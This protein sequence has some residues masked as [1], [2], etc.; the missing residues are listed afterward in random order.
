MLD[1]DTAK[2]TVTVIRTLQERGVLEKVIDFFQG[3]NPYNIIVVGSS[4]TGKTSFLKHMVG[5]EP[6]IDRFDRSEDTEAKTGN[7]GS[8]LFRLETV[9]GQKDGTYRDNRERAFREMMA[10]GRLGVIN[11]VSYG[12]HEGKTNPGDVFD[13][14]TVRP[15]YLDRGRANE[16]EASSEW[17]SLFFGNGGP[18][19]WLV[20]LVNKAD[21]WWTPDAQDSVMSY[22]E[23]GPY[24]E[25]L[26]SLGVPH[27]IL[28]YSVTTQPFYGV[29][30]A[31]GNY[32]DQ[33]RSMDHQ[34]LVA[35][36]LEYATK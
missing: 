7:I 1:P 2:L 4:G 20:T 28:P 8:A 29:S 9:P 36:L 17:A 13:S 23:T 12:F 21:L 6:Y 3:K 35:R 33:Q 25:K 11:V 18:G 24:Y 34:K 14:G 15:E 10:V 22:Y 5:V 32:S 19:R 16:I 27:S 31:T 26:G 30:A